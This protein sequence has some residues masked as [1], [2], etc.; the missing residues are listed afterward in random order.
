[1]LP[2]DLEDARKRGRQLLEALNGTVLVFGEVAVRDEVLRLRLLTLEDELQAAQKGYA[3]DDVKELPKNF[4]ADIGTVLMTVVAKGVQPADDMGKRYVG[5]VLASVVARSERLVKHIPEGF[6]PGLRVELL[7]RHADALLTIGEQTEEES[8]FDGAVSNFRR[9]LSEQSYSWKPLELST[10]KRDL[11]CAL[12]QLGEKRRDATLFHQA[13]ESLRE[14]DKHLEHK[15]LHWAIVQNNLSNALV[16]LGELEGS[17]GRY[18]EAERVLRNTD[19]MLVSY[20]ETRAIMAHNLGNLLWNVGEKTSRPEFF[21]N[22]IEC[23]RIAL[24]CHPADAPLSKGRSTSS[25]AKLLH[26]QGKRDGSVELLREAK[27]MALVAIAFFSEA[28]H[29][30][31]KT[32]AKALLESIDQSLLKLAPAA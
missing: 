29:Q 14:A 22:A 25:L 18:K 32:E 13:I 9:A 19:S 16:A 30:R 20:P 2:S 8:M 3:L 1:L 31:Y 21:S 4:S 11:G 17:L 24:D 5:D 10:T 27:S 26:L 28:D 15:D 12:R 6:T 23:Y 7:T